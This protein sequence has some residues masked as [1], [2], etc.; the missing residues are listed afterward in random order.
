MIHTFCYIFIELKIEMKINPNRTSTTDNKMPRIPTC[1]NCGADID[2]DCV[3]RG[4]GKKFCDWSCCVQY[5]KPGITEEIKEN[6]TYIK[7]NR[8][9]I[10]KLY[11]GWIKKGLPYII[12]IG[13]RTISWD[14]E[15]AS[16]KSSYKLLGTI[17]L[18]YQSLLKEDAKAFSAF[19]DKMREY[20]DEYIQ[21]AHSSGRRKENADLCMMW[22]KQISCAKKYFKV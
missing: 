3:R 20:M 14:D 11:G 21:V 12:S 10:E 8:K 5:G 13:P 6:I 2:G 4:D 15:L 17:L 9:D 1:P 18:T 16:A 7:G 22:I 19:E